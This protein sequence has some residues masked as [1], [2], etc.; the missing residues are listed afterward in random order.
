MALRHSEITGK[1]RDLKVAVKICRM[2]KKKSKHLMPD[3]IFFVQFN[4]NGFDLNDLLVRF[5]YVSLRV[6]LFR[7]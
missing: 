5:S 2:G 3:T 1:R 6:L 7:T 4:V